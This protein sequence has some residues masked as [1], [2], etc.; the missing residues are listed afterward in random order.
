[1]LPNLIIPGA[2]KSGTT[3]LYR[4][5]ADH[6]ACCMSQPKEPMIFSRYRRIDDDLYK[7]MFG[8]PQIRDD[9]VLY[10]GDSS[11]T[12][13]SL[14]HVAARLHATLGSNIRIICIL[15]N[16]VERTCSAYW[17]MV[18]RF[19]ER[20]SLTDV[21]ALQTDD[22]DDAIEFEERQLDSAANRS[23]ILR[24]RYAATLGD[25][26]WSF[27]Y[28]RN[29]H[30]VADLQRYADLFGRQRMLV[31]TLEDLASDPHSTYTQILQFLN[32]PPHRLPHSLLQPANVTRVPRQSVFV[33]R[34]ANVLQQ[35]PWAGRQLRSRF[36][37]RCSD[38]PPETPHDVTEHLQQLFAASC[39]RLAGF[40]GRPVFGAV[41]EGNTSIADL[42]GQSTNHAA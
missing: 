14:P 20:R 9:R 16:P 23:E 4:W 11:T 18:K 1:M 30:Y 32:L 19:D 17:H 15:R 34:T 31:L 40:L 7:G 8:A 39:R 10:R 2:Q 21:C 29:S 36:L 33:R 6:P 35:V 5:L 27:R 22:L 13:L 25:K 3:T 28:L 42:S 24:D 38:V 26:N 12:Y 41:P 37:R